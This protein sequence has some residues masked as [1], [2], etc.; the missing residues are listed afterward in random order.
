MKASCSGNAFYG[1]RQVTLAGACRPPT[2]NKKATWCADKNT[3]RSLRGFLINKRFYIAK[4]GRLQ[5]P[6]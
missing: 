1:G 3:I 2:T 5:T 6:S 4:N